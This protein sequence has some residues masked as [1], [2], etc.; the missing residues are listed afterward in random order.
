MH[1]TAPTG[2]G[3][4]DLGPGR[5][6]LDHT[7]EVIANVDAISAPELIYPEAVYLHNGESYFIRSLDLENKVAHAERHEMD[8]YTQAVLEST[9]LITQQRNINEALATADLAYGNVDVSWKTVAFKKIK[10]STFFFR[11]F[12]I[13]VFVQI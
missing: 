1:Q 10:F 8:Y 7:N 2:D 4:K 3:P 6:E 13:L 9:V 12:L 5:N 11:H